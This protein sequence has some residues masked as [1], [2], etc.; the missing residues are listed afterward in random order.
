MPTTRRRMLCLTAGALLAADRRV[1]GAEAD[2]VADL[3]REILINGRKGGVSW[4][5]PRACRI[6]A[7][8]GPGVFMTLQSITGSDV[9]GPVHWMETRDNGR[10]WTTP[11]PV[12]GLGRLPAA[13]GAQEG[14]CDVVPEYHAATGSI[15]AI[16]HNVFYKENIFFSAQPSRWPVYV[17]RR[18]D[19][20]WTPRRR[21][22]WNDPRGA[23]IYS[24]NCAQRLNLPDGR[25]LIPFT[26]GPTVN[27]PRSVSTVLA[28][29]EGNQLTIRQTGNELTNTVGRGLL[30]PSLAFLDGVYY[31]TIRAEDDH[32]YLTRSSDGLQW[33]PQI[34]WAWDNG[35]L[36]TMSTTQQRWLIH[37][38]AL[39]LV[40]TRK[41]ASNTTVPRWRSPLYFAQVDR[42]SLRL[43]RATERIAFPLEGDGVANGKNV[44][45]SGNFQTVAASADE[46]W[47]TDGEHFPGNQYHG[48]LR[49]ARV[50]WA[51]PNRLVA[52]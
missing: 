15:L 49:L 52:E 13:D 5:H 1:I 30:E 4:F 21:L 38:D 50:K 9:F 39:Y 46:S 28:D 45:Y 26:F 40:Y 25:V 48:N 10:T 31:M 47:I 19:G 27:S 12:P 20:S 43:I 7:P 11:Q 16:G 44:P 37:S 3:K 34:A 17:V 35:E 6:P 33:Q 36:L 24:C 51:Q 42:A 41:D 23:Y 32:G 29:F 22:E 14:V 8:A 18:A 2:L